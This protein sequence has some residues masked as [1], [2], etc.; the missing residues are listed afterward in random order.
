MPR[1]KIQRD[2]EAP[3]TGDADPLSI[4]LE[5][6]PRRSPKSRY[7]PGRQTA[8]TQDGPDAS[9][10]TPIPLVPS[11]PLGHSPAATQ[12]TDEEWRLS[13][14]QA[15]LVELARRRAESLSLYRPLPAQ[16][17]F[18]RSRA[19]IRLLRG[20][21]R[22]GKTLPAA[23]ELARAATGQDPHGKYP[24]EGGLAFLV[25]KDERHLGDVL[26]KKLFRAGAFFMI[27]DR[28]TGLWRAWNPSDP[29]DVARDA[30]K[31]KAPPL[32][33][34]R[35]VKNIAWRNK[36][37]NVPEKITL[38]NGWE[39]SFFSSLG[40]P[41]QGSAIN[42]C[43]LDEE[44]VD[45]DWLPEMLAR[46]PDFNG[47]LFWSATP[48]AGTEHLFDLHERAEAEAVDEEPSCAEFEIL[49]ADNSFMSARAKADFAKNITSEAERKVRI[50]GQ[51]A[52]DSFKIYPEFGEHHLVKDFEPPPHWTRY[53]FVD[54]GR[55]RCAVLFMAVPPPHEDPHRYFYDELYI[56]DC[57][58]RLF[59]QHVADK[60]RNRPLQAMWIDHQEGR[61]YETGSG[62]NIE[63]QY[64]A[65]LAK[66]GVK[67]VETGSDFWPAP[68]DVHSRLEALRGWLLADEAGLT[69]IRVARRCVNLKKEMERYRYKRDPRTKLPTDDPNKRNDHLC[70]CG[71]YAALTDP[72]YRK[73]RK[74][75]ATKPLVL[76]WLDAKRA[77]RRKRMKQDGRPSVNL[78]PG[79]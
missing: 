14:K 41:P 51:F 43:W 32:I 13:R 31:K 10:M 58:A 33:P 70:D 75:S 36:K 11:Q 16:H 76:A 69:K 79:S 6:N 54:P 67:S 60:C 47:V 63:A 40:K 49:L 21:N 59:A 50:D 7:R 71:G 66:Q 53:I 1:K 57:D 15:I 4:P 55:Q 19:Q 26:Y 34:P 29:A 25:G 52:I 24:K 46:L 2:R 20:S 30:E 17:Q 56:K 45:P 61:K 44:I 38:K 8:S 39:L 48:Q 78:G 74:P 68:A 23:V 3:I 64:S 22:G 5:Q 9:E 35:F 18:H 28:V 37:A 77:R 72:P 73:P 42:I 27:R 65:A 62:R 12:E